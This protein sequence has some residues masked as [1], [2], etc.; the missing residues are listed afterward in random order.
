MISS[1]LMG[2]AALALLAGSM[3]FTAVGCSSET[4]GDDDDDVVADGGGSSSG[5]VRD[6]GGSSS[7]D[8]TAQ[9]PACYDEET[10]LIYP[11]AAAKANQGVCTPAQ[12]AAVFDDCFGE[13]EPGA[14]KDAAAAACDAALEA[15]PAC[16]TCILGPGDWDADG[17]YTP[18]TA[19]TLPG[20]T[21]VNAGQ[22]IG[23]LLNLSACVPLAAGVDADCTKKF[24]DQDFCTTTACLE[25]T[26]AENS[27]CAN[28]SVNGENEG[29][30]SEVFAGEECNSAIN[31]KEA[32]VSAKCIGPETPAPTFDSV[33]RRVANYFC[34]TGN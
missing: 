30:C 2:L 1:K 31:A 34:A 15:A 32:D 5:R 7:G 26:G 9:A 29:I 22:G 20:P 19:A 28:Y 24:T 6:G 18:P 14:D 12:I 11:F 33:A 16:T 4:T 23:F 10:A 13:D 27:A 21:L 25:C 8:T 3:G 17:A